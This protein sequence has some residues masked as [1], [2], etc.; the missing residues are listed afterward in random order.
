MRYLL[1]TIIL[2]LAAVPAFAQS[3]CTAIDA[4]YAERGWQIVPFENSDTFYGWVGL[5]DDIKNSGRT[6]WKGEDGHLRWT[7]VS[8]STGRTFEF[9]WLDL[10]ITTDAKGRHRGYHHF[11]GLYELIATG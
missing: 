5:P 11:C 1:L 7:I 2:L 9:Y 10:E 3:D 4:D 8:K 6:K